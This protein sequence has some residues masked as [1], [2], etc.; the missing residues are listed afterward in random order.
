MMFE[1]NSL[2]SGVTKIPNFQLPYPLLNP[3]HWVKKITDIVGN[4]DVCSCFTGK[5]VSCFS[6]KI[7]L[8]F[9]GIALLQV[10]IAAI[11]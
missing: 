7:F 10:A 8:C 11:N 6:G 4:A 3:M 1:Y 9:S 2:P 5:N